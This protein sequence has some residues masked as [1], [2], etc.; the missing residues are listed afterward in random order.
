MLQPSRIYPLLSR[1]AAALCVVASMA[2]CTFFT[3]YYDDF[4]DKDVPVHTGEGYDEPVRD[5]GVGYSVTYQYQ[6]NVRVLTD[7]IQ[8]YVRQVYID[9]TGYIAVVDFD[10]A[11]PKDLLPKKGEIITCVDGPHFP[12]GIGNHVL[13]IAPVD[14][15]MRAATVAANLGEIFKK[16]D[17]EGDLGAV[18]ADQ[19]DLQPAATRASSEGMDQVE[20]LQDFSITPDDK[21]GTFHFRIPLD[22]NITIKNG[23]A[24]SRDDEGYSNG[25]YTIVGSGD[26]SVSNDESFWDHR[27]T[28]KAI[29][30]DNDIPY[31]VEIVDHSDL[32]GVI[33]AS[34]TLA[35]KL[36]IWEKKNFLPA[37]AKIKIKVVSLRIILG[38]DITASLA[39]AGDFAL[40]FKHISDINVSLDAFQLVPFLGAAVTADNLR[41]SISNS[42]VKTK[43][44]SMMGFSISG[45]PGVTLSLHFGVGLFNEANSFTI[46]P[47]I[48][49][50]STVSTPHRLVNGRR[51]VELQEGVSASARVGLGASFNYGFSMKGTFNAILND[52]AD[53]A[54]IVQSVFATFFIDDPEEQ[55]AYLKEAK[56]MTDWMRELVDGDTNDAKTGKIHYSPHYFEGLT[57]KE[58]FTWMPKLK[59]MAVYK[60]MNSDNTEV[61][62]KGEAHF[63]EKGISA[64]WNNQGIMPCM[65][66]TKKN[67]DSFVDFAVADEGLIQRDQPLANALYR[68]F[69]FTDVPQNEEYNARLVYFESSML[70]RFNSDY[71]RQLFNNPDFTGWYYDRSLE[72]NTILPG[73]EIADIKLV[74]YEVFE[75]QIMDEITYDHAY[76][77]SIKV[78]VTNHAS[79]KQWGIEDFAVQPTI[80]HS[81]DGRT[82]HDGYYDDITLTC[83]TSDPNKII[84]QLWPYYILEDGKK[85]AY[86]RGTLITQT[87]YPP[88]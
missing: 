66:L 21:G 43:D 76:T 36:R 79:I 20:D 47:T 17:F 53:D 52:L 51:N 77:F 37:K 60:E 16:L 7:D 24:V 8:Q 5:G 56:A 64:L 83:Y 32:E 46:D 38:V 44:L 30:S 18:L 29:L 54:S 71:Y 3:D 2:S 48:D 26:V 12:D 33:H 84:I 81:Y 39:L 11:T 80:R 25:K 55:K 75:N 1:C 87:F 49:L 85:D 67:D 86:G 69:T 22:K 70:Q 9:S 58:S 63:T 41:K 10:L 73:V 15:V 68:H 23:S 34:G 65:V 31:G 19:V 74:N 14:G 57:K 27:L 72:C 28:F 45:E 59:D 13:A 61:T 42:K 4:E 40:S 78:Y 6:S 35:G 50:H 62:L 88:K 82:N